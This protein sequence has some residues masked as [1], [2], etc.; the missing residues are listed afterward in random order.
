MKIKNKLLILFLFSSIII[1]A[2]ELDDKLNNNLISKLDKIFKEDQETRKGFATVFQKYGRD[3][4]ETK[5]YL[6]EMKTKDSLNVIQV[7]EIL[8][9]YGWLGPEVIGENGSTTL[10]LVIQHAELSVQEKYLTLMREAVEKGNAKA[11]DLALLEDRIA[12]RKGGRQIYGSQIGRDVTTGNLI[13]LPLE[14]P[15]MVNERRAKVGLEPIEDYISRFGLKWN[16]EEYKKELPEI[17]KRLKE[18]GNK[19]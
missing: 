15:D 16:V 5:K 18:K 13:V 3:G 10:F 14:N 2:Q 8:D 9:K 4:E 11:K 17:E 1:M 12:L 6:Q 19:F 7:Q